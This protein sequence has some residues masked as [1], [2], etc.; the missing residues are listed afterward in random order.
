LA[1]KQDEIRARLAVRRRVREYRMEFGAWPKSPGDIEG[2][3]FPPLYYHRYGA[4]VAEA[5]TPE[6][7]G[8]RRVA[9]ASDLASATYDIRIGRGS[10]CRL[11]IELP[12]AFLDETPD[13][14]SKR[15]RKRD[16]GRGG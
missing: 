9:V 3:L 8:F 15:L 2:P 14:P 10:A 1:A 16:K 4:D 7:F 11:V 5:L 6:N 12:P 13:D